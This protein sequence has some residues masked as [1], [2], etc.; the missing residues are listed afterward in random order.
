MRNRAL[1]SVLA[2]A[3][4]LPALATPALGS[5]RQY[6]DGWDA[7]TYQARLDPVPHH[8]KADSGSDVNGHAELVEVDGELE[9]QIVETI[10]EDVTQFWTYGPEEYMENETYIDLKGTWAN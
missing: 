8:P 9:N 10:A 4:L 1:F 6:D 5:D 3:A 2:G 7:A